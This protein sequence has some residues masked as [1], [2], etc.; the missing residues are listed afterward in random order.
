MDLIKLITDPKTISST[1]FLCFKLCDNGTSVYDIV[2]IE[3][4]YEN[5]AVKTSLINVIEYLFPFQDIIFSKACV[6][7]IGDLKKIYCKFQLRD[8]KMENFSQVVNIINKKI[9]TKIPASKK[10]IKI[11]LTEKQSKLK[12]VKNK[13]KSSNIALGKIL[14]EH[15]YAKLHLN[16]NENNLESEI[17]YICAKLCKTPKALK[18][19]L[20][21]HEDKTCPYCQKVLKSNSYFNKHVQGHIT[22]VKKKRKII[23]YYCDVCPYKTINKRD[24]KCHNYKAHL[25]IRPYQCEN[26]PKSFYKKSNLTEHLLIH[27]RSK[28]FICELC[29]IHFSVKR[30]LIQHLMLHEGRRDYECKFCKRKFVSNS[31][32]NEHIKRSHSNKCHNCPYCSKKF[33]IRK[34]KINHLKL[35]HWDLFSVDDN[36]LLL[37]C[38]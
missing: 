14:D 11:S 10:I 30:S 36:F 9:P 34:D 38:L 5:F 12:N 18:V 20:N 26:C 6:D 19:H 7:C 32:K 24:L 2:D 21:S 4:K 3:D 35:D 27:D 16:S 22:N 17:C 31:R 23:H 33:A 13:A 37:D 28:R 29:G 15:Q 8:V 1:C 25:H